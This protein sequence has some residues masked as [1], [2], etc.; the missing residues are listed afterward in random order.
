MKSTFIVGLWL[1]SIPWRNFA[2]KASAF[3]FCCLLSNHSQLFCLT[4]ASWFS[5]GIKDL[6]TNLAQQ[7]GIRCSLPSLYWEHP[8]EMDWRNDHERN[9][10]GGR[11]GEKGRHMTSR[12]EVFGWS[13]PKSTKK[14]LTHQHRNPGP[15]YTGRFKLGLQL[16][17][18]FLLNPFWC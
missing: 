9:W 2:Q 7:P 8:E 6:P 3:L 15:I 18:F 11:V 4:Q 13:K 5:P 17:F 14:Y 12:T 16:G 1:A 10:C